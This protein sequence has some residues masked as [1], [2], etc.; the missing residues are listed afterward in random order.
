M[1]NEPVFLQVRGSRWR[2]TIGVVRNRGARC[3]LTPCSRRPDIYAAPI[4]IN[5]A[6]R[7]R[8][9]TGSKTY[10]L[11]IMMLMSGLACWNPRGTL[12]SSR[13]DSRA[14]RCRDNAPREYFFASTIFSS[15][16]K[17]SPFHPF[18]P[19]YS[20]F[21]HFFAKIRVDVEPVNYPS[22]YL[23][24]RDPSIFRSSKKKK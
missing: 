18:N 24:W 19:G 4:R 7:H 23:I 11:V 17:S 20:R 5:C 13:R 3:Y 6:T 14:A 16:E 1:N 15:N 21:N 10:R 12:P 9:S 8:K 22:S 2:A